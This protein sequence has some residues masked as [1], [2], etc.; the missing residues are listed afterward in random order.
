M[1]KRIKK[2]PKYSVRS[3][4]QQIWERKRRSNYPKFLNL[5]ATECLKQRIKFSVL[6]W[7]NICNCEEKKFNSDPWSPCLVFSRSANFQGQRWQPQERKATILSN[8][9]SVP[10]LLI[11]KN[12]KKKEAKIQKNS[13]RILKYFLGNQTETWRLR[14]SKRGDGRSRR[15]RS[16]CRSWDRG[17]GW[18]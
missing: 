4:C 6:N 5:K 14:F 17:R 15:N 18:I 2:V 12:T 9:V 1:P 7:K 3:V 10:L 16:R 13:Q 11:R 8:P